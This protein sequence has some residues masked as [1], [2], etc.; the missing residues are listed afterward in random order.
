MNTFYISV[1]KDNRIFRGLDK[2]AFDLNTSSNIVQHAE[3]FVSALL[4]MMGIIYSDDEFSWKVCRYDSSRY[5]SVSR[6]R[7]WVFE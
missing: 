7:N 5:W 6:S 4:A 3:D 1:R 2:V